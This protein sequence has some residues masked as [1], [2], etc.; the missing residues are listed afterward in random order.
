MSDWTTRALD[1]GIS[2][3][4]VIILASILE[5]EGKNSEEKKLI[6]S[7][8]HNRKRIGMALESEAVLRYGLKKFK[9]ELTKKDKADNSRY[10]TFK[11]AGFPPTPI[12]NPS[13]RSLKAALYPTDTAHLYYF[14]KPDG[15]LHF[16]DEAKE[17]K[18]ALK[19][20]SK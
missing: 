19:K 6:S 17:Y 15:K 10:N 4:E 2:P 16:A 3:H 18:K 12:S 20:F 14:R 13:N 7:V 5:K 8:F 9:G 11:A 1:L